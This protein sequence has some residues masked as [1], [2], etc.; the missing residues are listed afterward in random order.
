[1]RDR[2]STADGANFETTPHGI[3]ADY[4][5]DLFQITEPSEGNL[6]NFTLTTANS[7]PKYI[8][9]KPASEPSI[10]IMRPKLIWASKYSSSMESARWSNCY[11]L[12]RSEFFFQVGQAPLGDSY[13]D[14]ETQALRFADI[15]R[16]TVLCEIEADNMRV[17][18][19]YPN[20]I[21]IHLWNYREIKKT[22]FWDVRQNTTNDIT[23]FRKFPQ[24]DGCGYSL[25][26]SPYNE[27]LYATT[28]YRN[29]A[30]WDRRKPTE[31]VSSWNRGYAQYQSQTMIWN[32]LGILVTGCDTIYDNGARGIVYYIN[33]ETME[34][35]NT[36]LFT[37]YVHRIRTSKKGKLV[38]L[39]SYNDAPWLE[40]HD[41]GWR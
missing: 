39:Q 5:S 33:P 10:E 18:T 28:H 41:Y 40:I 31:V 2:I 22:V 36:V 19:T 1:M 34:T 11:L 7:P 15:E 37:Q 6:S 23:D 20:G 26:K 4:G 21:M 38:A 14:D 30:V 24:F 3:Y 8:T 12:N 29:V 27:N 17:G 13:S 25:Q 32:G 9:K 35:F 16:G